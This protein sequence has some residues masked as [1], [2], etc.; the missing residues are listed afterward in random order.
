M[1][2]NYLDERYTREPDMRLVQS[3]WF[4]LIL[5]MQRAR[6]IFADLGHKEAAQV[7]AYVAT[8]RQH[9]LRHLERLMQD[10]NGTNRTE[11]PGVGSVASEDPLVSENRQAPAEETG[12]SEGGGHD[13]RESLVPPGDSE[14]V[15]AAPSSGVVLKADLTLVERC[16][17]RMVQVAAVM[18]T[19]PVNAQQLE[20]AMSFLGRARDLARR[21]HPTAEA[22]YIAAE[23]VLSGGLETGT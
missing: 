6:N 5:Q 13:R 21:G 18:R 14:D 4:A 12:A 16:E 19:K 1:T 8:F 10:S 7:D 22:R 15:T 2:I 23:T 20:V 9:A 17:L 3:E 11:L